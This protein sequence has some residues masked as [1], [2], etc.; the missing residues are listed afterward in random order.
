MA[1]VNAEKHIGVI[2]NGIKILSFEKTEAGF[3]F[4]C[5]CRCGNTL[6]SKS[7]YIQKRSGCTKCSPALYR[8]RFESYGP[9]RP[10]LSKKWRSII[11]RCQNPKD[12]SYH[13]Y[14]ARGISICEEWK[15]FDVFFKWAIETGFEKGLTIDR[16][17]VNG[18]YEPSNCR[19]ASRLVQNNNTRVNVY[20]E[21]D[22]ERLTMG[23]W[24]RK[25]GKTRS[26]VDSRLRIGWSFENA[27]KSPMN[28]KNGNPG[29]FR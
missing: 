16:I 15:D 11:A 29:N 7:P 10:V 26:Q 2:K 17:N 25:Y 24:A 21:M 22:G 28:K 13:D 20:Y 23:D 9:L 3:L 4:K 6:Y 18:N 5:L 1:L 14:G 12:N 19:W 8:L 27:V